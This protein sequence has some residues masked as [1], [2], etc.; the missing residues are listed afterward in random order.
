[1]KHPV[2]DGCEVYV[3]LALAE[4]EEIRRSNKDPVVF[5]FYRGGPPRWI[6]A[7]AK[8]ENGRGFLVTAYLTDALKIREVVWRK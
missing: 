4:P 2:M 7:V 1:M 8:R 6:C 5:L 3:Q